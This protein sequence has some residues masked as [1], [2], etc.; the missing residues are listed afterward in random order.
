MLEEFL[1]N[2]IIIILLQVIEELNKMR[3]E[4]NRRI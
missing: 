3:A 2:R 4:N 1:F